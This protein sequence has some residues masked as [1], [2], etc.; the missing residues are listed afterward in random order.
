M[1]ERFLAAQKNWRIKLTR[2]RRRRGR[3]ELR[4]LAGCEVAEAAGR[5][6][7][8]GRVDVRGH[9]RKTVSP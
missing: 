8:G 5:A 7:Y 4:A 1:N 9:C 6:D 3:G 2:F